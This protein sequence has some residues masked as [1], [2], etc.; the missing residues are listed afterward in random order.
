[1]RLVAAEMLLA[2]TTTAIMAALVLLLGPTL[3]QPLASSDNV[4]AV[5][6]RQCLDAPLTP[7]SESGVEG[8]ARLCID[9]ETVRPTLLARGLQEGAVYT[10]WLAYFDRPSACFH[11]PC[12]FLDLRGD[13]PI[14]VLGRIDGAVVSRSREVELRATFR[15]FQVSSGAQVTLLI[16]SQGAVS[17]TDSRS[18]ARQLLTPRMFDLGAPLA[19]A[20][21]DPAR[22]QL[23]AQVIFA[24]E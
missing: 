7:I 23:H 9:R 20:L 6:T 10:A 19:G 11:T 8:A 16:L 17:E 21:A 12:G 2:I 5:D 24:L 15:D 18:R 4:A 3:A 14:G 13:D 22:G 1:M